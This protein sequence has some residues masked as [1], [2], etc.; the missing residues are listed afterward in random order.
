MQESLSA[1]RTQ[2]KAKQVAPEC[3]CLHTDAHTLRT[4]ILVTLKIAEL[5][6]GE[7]CVFDVLPSRPPRKLADTNAD[8]SSQN[9]SSFFHSQLQ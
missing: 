1:M 7:G 9:F 2:L 3:V 6:A 5:Q 4:V 8:V